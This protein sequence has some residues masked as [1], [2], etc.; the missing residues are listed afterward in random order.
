MN[1]DRIKLSPTA[2]DARPYL[3]VVATARNDN[4]GGDLAHRMQIFVTALAAQCERHRVGAELIVVEWNPPEDNPPLAAALR[5]P[6][7]PWCDIRVVRV[8]SDIHA[9]L[10]HA[11]RLPLFQM[12]AKNVGI[13][14]ARGEYVLATNV[15]VLLSDGLMD[16]IAQRR[17]IPGRLYRAD[18]HDVTADIPVDAPVEEQLRLCASRV[19]RICQREGTLD[20]RD[21]AFYRIY[22]ELSKLPWWLG[23]VIQSFYWARRRFWLRVATTRTIIDDVIDFGKNV[24]T[25]WLQRVATFTEWVKGWLE[26]HVASHGPLEPRPQPPRRRLRRRVAHASRL[27]LPRPQPPRHRRLLLPRVAR[28]ERNAPARLRRFAAGLQARSVYYR[29]RYRSIREAW[30]WEKARVRLHTNASGD[31]TLMSRRDWDAVRGYAELQLFSMHIDGLLLYQAHYAGIREHFLHDPVYHLEHGSGFKPDVDGLKA[32]NERLERGAIPQITNEQ[33]MEW[34]MTM[35]REKRPILFNDE[36]WGMANE[37]LEEERP[38][39]R[40]LTQAVG[41]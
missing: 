36:R 40:A 8:P 37:P 10:D 34:A 3:S 18:R 41:S 30:E 6:E 15:D 5:W 20:L 22:H 16:V 19:I 2:A 23:F 39:E 35:Y 25:A 17:L 7:T 21:G 32:L 38:G 13:R 4:H 26:A 28:R 33:F 12:I 11:D 31:F 1:I 27:L 9:R 29:T 24:A 14:R